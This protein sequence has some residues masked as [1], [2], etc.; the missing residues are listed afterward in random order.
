[1]IHIVVNTCNEKGSEYELRTSQWKCN[2]G[3]SQ[4]STTKK[5]MRGLYGIRSRAMDGALRSTSNNNIK[6]NIKVLRLMRW[7]CLYSI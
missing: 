1:M 7:A 2:L 4:Q 3:M 5:Y 6:N